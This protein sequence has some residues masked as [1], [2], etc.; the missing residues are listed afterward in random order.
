[1][2]QLGYASSA[3][4]D[5]RNGDVVHSIATLIDMARPET[6]YTHNIA[7][8][9]DTHV[10]VTLRTLE[11]IRSLPAS[12]RPKKLYGMECWRGLDWV[13]DAEKT[14]F[15]ASKHPNL[16]AALCGVF[17]SQIMGGKRYDLAMMGRRAAN[18]TM[19]AS[20]G[21]DVLTEAIYG[22]DMSS[23]IDSDED[24]A[25]FIAGFIER[26]SQDVAARIAKSA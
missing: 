13:V 12:A 22:L 11:A 6:M 8:K 3:V 20:H 7:D 23:L 1:M 9:H 19:L 10:A 2:V 15:D 4:K 25:A 26:F 14:V 16:S 5:A 18:A 17:D 21:V 24:P